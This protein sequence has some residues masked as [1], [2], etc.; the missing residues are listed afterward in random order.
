M[1]AA[2]K[3][4]AFVPV[5]LDDSGIVQRAPLSRPVVSR[6]FVVGRVGAVLQAVPIGR[7]AEH[8]VDEAAIAVLESR[9][10]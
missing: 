9:D 5:L 6:H 1:D 8:V 3:D 2:A 4:V 10:A 7:M